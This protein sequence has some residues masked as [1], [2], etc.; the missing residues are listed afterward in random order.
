VAITLGYALANIWGF[1]AETRH[2]M[3]L[4]GLRGVA[5]VSV[6]S[7]HVSSALGLTPM[8]AHGYLAV[9]FFFMLS[10]V[11]MANAYEQ[12][13][14]YGQ[15]RFWEFVKIRL[16]RLYPLIALGTLLGAVS[17]FGHIHHLLATGASDPHIHATYPALF[18]SLA[19]G[20]LILPFGPLGYS[21]MPLDLPLWS[22]FLEIVI[23]LVYAAIA[24]FLTSRMLGIL[25]IASAVVFIVQAL[26][27]GNLY[28]GLL[29]S[30][31]F[32]DL[33]RVATS[34][35]IG[36]ALL[37]LFRHGAFD[38][39]PRISGLFLALI[40]FASF[41]VPIY[42]GDILY[43]L[44]CIFLL[45]PAI[46]IYGLFDVVSARWRPV[47]ALAG[48]LSYPVYALHKPLVDHL[49]TLHRFHGAARFAALGA[50]IGI[51][52]MI[53]YAATVLYDE[54]LRAWLSA[55]LRRRPPAAAPIAAA[56]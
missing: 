44:G 2:F 12:K 29:T 34:F 28:L 49:T 20:L 7:L 9:D 46:I 48:R 31:M 4:D 32:I 37:R 19:L 8:P 16:I 5:A 6:V 24:R 15:L 45:Y 26:R 40:L 21:I 17:M 56:D 14:R 18:I 13:L 43:C 53:S 30:N 38:S 25:I 22:L 42:P 11:V 3:V 33:A 54:P 1:M 51:S 10:G 52:V 55:R 41:L 35:L 27:F 36:V 23:N 39:L 50:I 47:A